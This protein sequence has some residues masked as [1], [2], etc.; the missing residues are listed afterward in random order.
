MALGLIST[1]YTNTVMY[2]DRQLPELTFIHFLLIIHKVVI[3]VICLYN[4]ERQ[5]LYFNIPISY[6]NNNKYH[7]QINV[8]ISY[9]LL[10]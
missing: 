2:Y 5:I 4:I 6:N 10:G 3:S 8:D 9:R 7:L 1:L